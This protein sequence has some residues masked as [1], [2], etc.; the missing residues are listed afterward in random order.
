[1]LLVKQDTSAQQV[2][3]SWLLLKT[4]ANLAIIVQPDLKEKLFVQQVSIVLI[5]KMLAVNV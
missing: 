1:L 3:N 4:F 5:S 2:Q